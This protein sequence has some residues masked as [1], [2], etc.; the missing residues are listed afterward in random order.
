MS[1]MSRVS[2]VGVVSFPCNDSF[3][4]A[5]TNLKTG[6]VIASFFWMILSPSAYKA[7]YIELV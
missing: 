4:V 7:I 2:V 1:E 3:N 5:L 6:L